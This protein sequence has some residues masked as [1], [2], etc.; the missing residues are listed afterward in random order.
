MNFIL[1][2]YIQLSVGLVLGLATFFAAYSARPGAVIAILLLAIPFQPVE[3]RYGTLNMV[4][5]YMVFIVFMLRGRI[6]EWPLI[7]SVIAIAFAYLLSITQVHT[8]LYM[9][10][11]IYVITMGGNFALFYLVYNYFRQ[12]G[13]I[14]FAMKLF[15]GITILVLVHFGFSSVIG[16]Q[17][18][19]LLGIEELDLIVNQEAKRRLIGPFNG[20]EYSS[21]FLA[22]QILLIGYMMLFQ[23]RFWKQIVLLLLA[24]TCFGFLFATGSRG[25]LIALLPG[26]ILFLAL[27]RKNL[28]VKG[29]TKVGVVLGLFAVAAVVVVTLSEFNVMFERLT[30]THI[31]GYELDTRAGIFEVVAE[32]FSEK[33]VL[34]HGPRQFLPYYVMNPRVGPPPLGFNPHSLYFFLLLTIGVV[35]FIMYMAFFFLL[36]R[37]WWVWR[38][39]QHDEPMIEGMPR[40]ALVIMFVFLLTEYRIEFLRFNIS[41]Y[42]QYM[43]ALWAMMLAFTGVKKKQAAPTGESGLQDERVRSEEP[44]RMKIL[45][46]RREPPK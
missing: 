42:Q 18:F 46:A 30:G 14:N 15:L 10:H 6:H 37:R 2:H 12:E 23:N 4:L 11:M 26:G 39:Q 20:A 35:G 41:D 7:G 31:V 44:R 34:G 28:G 1:E 17:Q 38:R 3:T 9:E 36:T 5:T 16:F 40:L 27:F 22:I 29:F 19:S 13:D 25:G 21:D 32:K 24:M 33:P 45:R 8:F 43:F